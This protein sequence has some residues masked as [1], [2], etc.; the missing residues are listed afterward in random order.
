MTASWLH[1]G[2][3]ASG[4]IAALCAAGC[5]D[6]DKKASGSDGAV[7]QPDASD[8]GKKDAGGDDEEVDAGA[9]A[10]KVLCGTPAKECSSHKTSL[11]VTPA[12]CAENEGGDEVCGISST[13][14]LMGAEPK[15]LE[16]DAP[17][18]A[19]PSCGAFYDGLEPT[20][21]GGVADGGT[22]GNGR[23]DVAVT[24]QGLDIALTYPGCCT[25]AGFCSGDGS[26]GKADLGGGPIDSNSGFGCM[27][28]SIFFEALPEAVRQIPCDPKTGELKLPPAADAGTDAGTDAGSDAGT[29]SD[30]GDAG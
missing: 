20:P 30:A 21:D 11:G 29:G 5:G 19:S 24:L 18:V 15:F 1:R 10:P 27:K 6:D 17:G 9:V 3:V 12:G 7:A 2:L 14:I 25:A 22:K 16:K 13:A 23:I 26:K 28:S 8:D 4:M